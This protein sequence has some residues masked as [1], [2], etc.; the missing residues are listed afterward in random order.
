MSDR[1][2]M[3]LPYGAG[4]DR[5]SG[6]AVVEPSQFADLR[7]V[8]LL[9]G[10]AKVRKGNL[11]IG[12]LVDGV[13]NAF[14]KVLQVDISTGPTFVD[15][16]TDANDVG[17]ADWL[18]FPVAEAIGD[19][20]AL[21]FERRFSQVIFDYLHGTAGIGGV[22]V[23]EYWNGAAWTALAGVSDETTGFTAAAA[24]GRELTFTVPTNW[25]TTSLNGSAQLYFI[26]ARITTVY[27]TNPV[28][29]QG[30]IAHAY[31]DAVNGVH[32]IRQLQTGLGF[33]Y[34]MTSRKT[35]VNRLTGVGAFAQYVGEWFT[36]D[37]ES[38]TPR[39]VFADSYG[40][41]FAA[42][43]EPIYSRRAMSIYYE[44]D[45]LFGLGPL[46]PDGS[47][48]GDFEGDF[49][50]DGTQDQVKFR[51]VVNH[52]NYIFGWG[53]GTATDPDRPEVVRVCEPGEPLRWRR[54]DY[55]LAGSGGVPV[56]GCSPCGDGLAVFKEYERHHIFGYDRDNFGIGIAEPF[57]GLA[58]DRLKVSVSGAC[59]F[60]SL[61]GPRV[62]A[63]RGPS[64]DLALP[65]DLEAPSPSDLVD[66]GETED[67]FAEYLPEER[68]ILFVFGRRVYCLSIRNPAYPRWSYWELAQ[69]AFCGGL[70]YAGGATGSGDA[71]TLYMS[72]VVGEAGP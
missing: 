35:H 23:W 67:G 56:V 7:N 9:E 36:A 19:Y 13:S 62:A 6:V 41:V 30:F 28:L 17:N 42:H 64:T 27:S 44:N 26:R 51:G 39:L 34:V 2:T 65:L 24:D 66:A 3:K 31:V 47:P 21:G 18:P 53:Y 59:F 60:W 1:P 52:L 29:D 25:A 22:V 58:G 71:P 68:V 33:G 55:F 57:I 4:L 70:L 49:D 45:A 61:Q 5:G 15:E 50:N 43:A 37:D 48:N 14:G 69:P 11:E 10:K 72:S 54:D 32:P 16:T 20:L 38:L 46:N 8:I 63:N 12:R 40:K